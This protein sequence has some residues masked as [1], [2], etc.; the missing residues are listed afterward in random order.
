VLALRGA[1]TDNRRGETG[2]FHGYG[3]S[4]ALTRRFL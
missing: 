3:G 2:A 4:I 1:A